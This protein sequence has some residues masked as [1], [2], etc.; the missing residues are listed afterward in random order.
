MIV[1]IGN[2]YLKAILVNENKGP[3]KNDFIG[4]YEVMTEKKKEF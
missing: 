4:R 1:K 2:D 3:I